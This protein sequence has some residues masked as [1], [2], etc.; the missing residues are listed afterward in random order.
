M[1]RLRGISDFEKLETM[2]T[3]LSKKHDLKVY[4][5]GWTRKTYDIYKEKKKLSKAEHMARVESL[6]VDSG[7]IR[8]FDDR[9]KHFVEEL[10]EVMENTFELEEAVVIREKRPEY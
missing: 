7:E 8:F 1:V 10:A 4:V 3:E 9:A 5:T 6:A 2:I